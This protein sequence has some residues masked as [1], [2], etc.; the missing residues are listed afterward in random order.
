MLY[1]YT[2]D[3]LKN[4]SL[5]MYDTQRVSQHNQPWTSA[6][7]YATSMTVGPYSEQKDWKRKK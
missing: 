2:V 6:V 7:V 3:V 5:D 4:T 1:M